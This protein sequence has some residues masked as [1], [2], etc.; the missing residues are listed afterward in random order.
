M[1]GPLVGAIIAT[2]AL[3]SYVSA[4]PIETAA[5]APVQRPRVILLRGALGVFSRGLDTLAA[6]CRAD[7]MNVSVYPYTQWS[8]VADG[9]IREP[10]DAGQPLVLI[11]HSFGADAVLAMAN[12]LRLHGRHVELA[13]TL[14]SVT[15][16]HAPDNVGR[17]LN[18]YSGRTKY[19]P[20]PLWRGLPLAQTANVENINLRE[21]RDVAPSYTGH[22]NID[23]SPQVHQYV[24]DRIHAL[25]GAEPRDAVPT[26]GGQGVIQGSPDAAPPTMSLRIATPEYTSDVPP[27]RAKIDEPLAIPGAAPRAGSQAALETG[28]SPT[29]Q[30]RRHANPAVAERGGEAAAVPAQPTS[31]GQR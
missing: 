19:S 6:R 18:F 31:R 21:R 12:R 16:T 11:G 17:A 7:G 8:S 28:Y 1:H 26:E 9:L 3:G 20:I 5:S 13:V 14:E 23:D 4:D 30:L 24:L 2:L 15:H 25:N 22:G 27:L 10:S 29:A